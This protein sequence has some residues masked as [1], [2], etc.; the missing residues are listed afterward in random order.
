MIHIDPRLLADIRDGNC[1]AFVGAG[2]SAAAGLPSWPSLLRILAGA[3]PDD[4]A[5]NRRRAL[6]LGAFA[7][8]SE[9][10]V[11]MRVIERVLG[12]VVRV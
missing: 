6:G 10:Q 2:F 9:W 11:L 5:E 1:V 8:T 4:A 3:L 12:P 7:F